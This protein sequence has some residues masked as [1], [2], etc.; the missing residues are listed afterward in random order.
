[1]SN[2]K[3]EELPLYVGHLHAF[4]IGKDKC[5]MVL[6]TNGELLVFDIAN[7]SQKVNTNIIS[8]IRDHFKIPSHLVTSM[9]QT[10]SEENLGIYKN[11]ETFS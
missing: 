6:K 1:M 5:M 8:L 10:N 4:R 2:G 7:Q 3:R 9:K 11:Y